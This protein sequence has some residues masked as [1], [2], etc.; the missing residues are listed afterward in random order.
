MVARELPLPAMDP[1]E[2]LVAER[3]MALDAVVTGRAGSASRVASQSE[4]G[5]ARCILATFCAIDPTETGRSGLA[6]LELDVGG[7]STVRLA[8]AAPD[9]LVRASLCD[10]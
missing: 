9:W 3:S 1:A 7:A 6:M 2:P 5:R 4:L 8:G 10:D